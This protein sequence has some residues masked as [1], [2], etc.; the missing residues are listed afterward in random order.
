MYNEDESHIPILDQTTRIHLG[1][2]GVVEDV[3]C[4]TLTL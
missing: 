2:C 3:T 4:I 1:L